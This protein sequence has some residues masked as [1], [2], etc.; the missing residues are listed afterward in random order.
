MSLSAIFREVYP[1][2]S[3]SWLTVLLIAVTVSL[4]VFAFFGGLAL[5]RRRREE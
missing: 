5:R 3:I 2:N 1:D 4:Y